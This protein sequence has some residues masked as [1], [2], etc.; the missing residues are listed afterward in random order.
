[1]IVGNQKLSLVTIHEDILENQPQI[2]K[3]LNIGRSNYFG[4]IVIA[5]ILTQL[6]PVEL[7]HTTS[8][9]TL[10]KAL[11]RRFWCFTGNKQIAKEVLHILTVIKTAQNFNSAVKHSYKKVNQGLSPDSHGI[12]LEFQIIWLSSFQSG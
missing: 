1:M 8:E 2:S 6:F 7:G 9:K 3:E 11:F 12:D 4:L 5:I 10:E